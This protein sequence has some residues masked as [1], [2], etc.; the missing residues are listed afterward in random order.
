MKSVLL[1]TIPSQCIRLTVMVNLKM[2]RWMLKCMLEA[3]NLGLWTWKNEM[4]LVKMALDAIRAGA[5][6]WVQYMEYNTSLNANFLMML[7]HFFEQINNKTAVLWTR[8]L[9]ITCLKLKTWIKI[10]HAYKTTGF[11]S[12]FRVKEKK[13]PKLLSHWPK[14]DPSH[15]FCLRCLYC[16][17]FNLV[18]VTSVLLWEV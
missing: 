3:T 6:D 11:I 4:K 2:K 8:V 10:F 17:C 5:S 1:W 12:I 18:H 9:V 13:I 14:L 16:C 15:G 7:L